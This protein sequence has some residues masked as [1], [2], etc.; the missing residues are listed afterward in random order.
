MHPIYLKSVSWFCI[1]SLA[2][3]L[4][5]TRICGPGVLVAWLLSTSILLGIVRPARR[6]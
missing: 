5:A 6:L 2:A 1:A 3:A 4:I